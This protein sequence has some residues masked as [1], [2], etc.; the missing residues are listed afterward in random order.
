MVWDVLLTNYQT[1]PR[2]DRLSDV[3]L[4]STVTSMILLRN[5]TLFAFRLSD[6]TFEYRDFDTLDLVSLDTDEVRSMPQSGFTFP[7][8]EEGSR[9]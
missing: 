5:G 4:H 2:L 1:T 3:L 8:V 9:I 6:G 7:A